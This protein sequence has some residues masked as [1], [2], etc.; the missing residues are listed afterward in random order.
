MMS[1]TSKGGQSDSSKAPTSQPEPVKK[2]ESKRAEP[3]S[4]SEV[5]QSQPMKQQEKLLLFGKVVD[6]KLLETKTK[7][8]LVNIIFELN[9]DLVR[10]TS[11]LS[12]VKAAPIFKRDAEVKQFT[13]VPKTEAKDSPDQSSTTWYIA[14]INSKPN[15]EPIGLE[16]WDPVIVGRKQENVNPQVDLTEHDAEGLGVSRRH[17]LLRPTNASLLLTDLRSTNGTFHNLTRLDPGAPQELRDGDII[18][19][20]QL[21]FKIRIIDQPKPS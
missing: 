5:K 19:F 1:E 21:N 14:L 20:G 15:H 11:R 13:R 7:E 18:S 16:I 10:T 17:A 3:N 12:L 8:E 9:S 6:R 2:P 4:D